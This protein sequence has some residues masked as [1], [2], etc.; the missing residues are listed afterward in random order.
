MPVSHTPS[1][2]AAPARGR[3][4][5]ARHGVL[6]SP[7]PLRQALTILGAVVAVV[8][9]SVGAVGAFYVWD[10]ARALN[11]N[12][13]NIGDETLPPSLGEIEGGVNM[14]VVGTDSC[15][16]QDVKL[17]PRCAHDAGGER[18]DV[19]MLVHISDSPR[20][21]TVVSFPRDMVVPIP[22]CPAEGGGSY[23]AMSAQMIN[24][25]YMYGGLPCSVLTVEALTGIDIQYAAAIR[26]T[27]VINMSDAIGGVDVCLAADIK[28]KHTGL[29][30]KAGE[31]TLV[32]AE[33]L[34]FLRIRHGIGDGSDLGRISNQQQFMSSLVR[35]LQSDG[36]LSN[37]S[38]LF[39]IATTAVSQVQ[40]KQLVLSE[41]LTNP[42]RMVQIAMA[43]RSVP[44]KDI[45]FV[46]YPTVYAPGGGRVLP[47]TQA[48]DVL[49][50]AL[51]DNKPIKLTG[52]A[53]Q[54]YG[55]EVVGEAEQ[56]TPPPTPTGSGSASPDPTKTPKPTSTPDPTETAVDLPSDISGQTAADVTCTQAQR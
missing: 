56:P 21:V 51:A 37:P 13:V 45:V 23:S 4:P 43:V 34:Q 18:N 26:W 33:A 14:L 48:A 12:S 30:L 55:V 16:G 47:V 22:S 29:D 15:E 36:V 35:K 1:D 3:Q 9:L 52:S 27:G 38:T 32:G 19:T 39:N 44:Y 25:S 54:G 41:S 5:V 40:S 2:D 24:S 46:Q 8:A 50:E 31:H 20:R 10:A 49:F 28:D 7:S 53:S 17:F 11:E 6:T 42:Q